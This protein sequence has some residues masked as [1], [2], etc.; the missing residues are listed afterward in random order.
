MKIRW[1]VLI[2]LLLFLLIS[3]TNNP[4]AFSDRSY[5]STD[6]T[7][8]EPTAQYAFRLNM[9]STETEFA[10]Y[11][12]ESTIEHEER[13]VCIETTDPLLSSQSFGGAVPEIY[14]FSPER[15]DYNYISNHKLYS[16]VRD[17]KSVDYI[18]DVLLTVYGESAHYGTV[19]GYANYLAG[20]QNWNCYRGNFLHPSAK[21]ILDLNYLCFDEEFAAAA[22]VEAAKG[23]ACAFID[24]Y[25]GQYSEQ[26]LQQLLSSP[27][28]SINALAAYYAENG[29]TYAPSAIQY[30]HGGRSCDYLVYTDYGTFYIAKDWV[31]IHAELNPLITDGFLHS[32][33]AETKAFFE[34]NLRQMKQYQDLFQLNDY[35]ND[36]DIVFTNPIDA[37]K[38]S[39]YQSLN[40]R[41]YVYNVDS[42]MHEYIHSLTLTKPNVSMSSWQVEGFARYFSYY[43]DFYGMA[44]LN[45]DYNNTPNTP[46]LKYIHEYLAAINRPIDM[47]K[48]Y[49]ELE[50]IAV[51]SRSWT[52]PDANYLT[53]SSF[54]QYLVKQYGEEAVIHSIYGKGNSL[55]ESYAEL[56][57]GWNEHIE[58]HYKSYSKYK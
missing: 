45:Q 1:I 27:S 57:K 21:D 47:A 36:L 13:E 25:I 54:V 38:T 11:F 6:V 58:T 53:G 16:S 7:Y 30:G 23:I 50:N 29:V 18:T 46:E 12:F 44:L 19:F 14:I 39:F 32:N 28:E 5:V 56:V 10:K 24:S 40:H 48:D 9:D 22:D 17:W 3:C 26:A 41:I 34:T 31:D 52:N 35:N 49:A 15:Y 4:F 37:S 33:Y 20:N 2:T 43:Y 51:Y 55:P 8:S 42:L